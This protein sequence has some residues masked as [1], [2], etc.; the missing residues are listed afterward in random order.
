MSTHHPCLAAC[1]PPL[2][3]PSATEALFPAIRGR[4]RCCLLAH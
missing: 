4:Q 2:F 3:E 1:K